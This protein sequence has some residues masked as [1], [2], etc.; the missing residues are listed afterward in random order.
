MTPDVTPEATTEKDEPLR[1]AI[2]ASGSGSNLEALARHAL[3]GLGPGGVDGSGSGAH[4]WHPVLTV[5]DRENCGAVQRSSGLGIPVCIV[6]AETTL[7]RVL[8]EHGVEMVLLA[9]FLKLIPEGVVRRWEGRILNLHPSLLP[10]FGGRGMYGRHVHEAVLA[11]GVQITGVT[12]HLVKERFDEGRILAQWPVPVEPLDTAESLA[13]R[14]QGVEHLLYPIAAD[15]LARHLA[16]SSR[17]PAERGSVDPSV[18]L[19]SHKGE[20]VGQG[21]GPKVQEAGPITHEA[22]PVSWH[23][24]RSVSQDPTPSASPVASSDPSMIGQPEPQM[25]TSRSNPGLVFP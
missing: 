8:E 13:F 20:P 24:L 21:E 18:G 3:R 19:V 22:G 2:L 12:V 10:A 1:T 4:P 25:S 17:A 9:G 5:T 11:A 6:D 16:R 14:I 23:L 7:E 15:H